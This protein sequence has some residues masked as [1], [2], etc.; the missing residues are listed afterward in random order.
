MDLNMENVLNGAKN[1]NVLP[2]SE[3]IMRLAIILIKQSWKD[4]Y[5]SMNCRCSSFEDSAQVS[6][7]FRP[8]YSLDFH[9]LTTKQT[10]SSSLTVLASNCHPFAPL[11]QT[12]VVFISKRNIISQTGNTAVENSEEPR[13]ISLILEA[14]GN[15][16]PKSLRFKSTFKLCL[17][18]ISFSA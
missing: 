11:L 10:A 6:C 3:S 5:N 15:P 9:C 16:W 14:D 17:L 8:D 2:I 4:L 7:T 18:K 1:T 13:A 12:S